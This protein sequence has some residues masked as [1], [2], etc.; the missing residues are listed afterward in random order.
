MFPPAVVVSATSLLRL[1][2]RR[3]DQRSS[4]VKALTEH[5]SAHQLFADLNLHKPDGMKALLTSMR[6]RTV[7][8]VLLSSTLVSAQTP[9]VPPKNDYPVSQDVELGRQAAAE[10]RKQLP[11]MRDDAVTSY[12]DGIGQ[13]LVSAIPQ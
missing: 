1:A 3:Q 10:A 2:V 9:V 11:V 8:V 7:L 4:L 13:R 5:S 12:V 6:M